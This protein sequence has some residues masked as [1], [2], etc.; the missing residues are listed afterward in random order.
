MDLRTQRFDAIVVGS[1]AAG[2]WAAKSLTERGF[3]VLMLEAGPAL[4]PAKDFPDPREG[5]SR[6]ALLSRVGAVMGGQHVQGRSMSFTA[7]T[8]RY[9][10]NDRQNPYTTGA[11][12]PF[13]WYRGRQ[14][15]GRMHLWGR[16]ALRFSDNELHA[17]ARDGAGPSWPLD[18]ADLAPWYSTVERFLGVQG[19]ADHI[20][21]LPDGDFSGAHPITGAE[22]RAMA[23]LR[24]RWPERPV[25]TCRIVEHNPGRIPLPIAAAEK[26]GRLTLRPDAIV[27]RIDADVATG[28]AT[29]VTFRDRVTREEISVRAKAVVVCASALESTRLLLNSRSNAHPNGLG[30]RS[31][32]LGRYVT[33]KVMVFRAGPLAPLEPV[34]REDPYDFGAQ[35]GIY[36]PSFRN[37]TGPGNLGFKRGYSL[38]GSLGRI[39]PGWFFMA[40]G[41]MLP[42]F[43]NRVEID[44]RRRD[45]W[46]A[47]VA[48]ITVTHSD[49]ER[50]MVKDMLASL[51]EVAAACG[52]ATDTL[53]KESL[54]SKLAYRFAAPLVYTAEGALVPGSAAH[55]T[56]GAIMG[57]DPATSVLNRDNQLWDAANVFVT[58]AASFP[59]SPFQNPG[60][61][62]MALSAR[63]GNAVA[64]RL[65]RGEFA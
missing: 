7:Q 15:G 3:R 25:T 27:T 24:E 53:G 42:R 21:N 28:R 19:A 35:S 40:I 39:E 54:L 57:A 18:Y 8:R 26:T 1:G 45:A 14:V 29:G 61:T 20:E 48:R 47:P 55:E 65:E 13:N 9:F 11:R 59:S 52:L 30:G 12:T 46:G 56:G 44:P 37:V 51:D 43:E 22:A 33:D 2:G 5:E 58:D 4:D 49:N 63:A 38:L 60:L 62:I 32:A 23:A 64:D 34:G 50:A 31:G 41:E 36:I 6:V 17:G 10:V 16:N